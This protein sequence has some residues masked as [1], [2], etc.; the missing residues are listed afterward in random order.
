[1]NIDKSFEVVVEQTFDIDIWRNKIQELRD[2]FVTIYQELDL[3]CKTPLKIKG[4]YV[5]SIS[6]TCDITDFY[7]ILD[8]L[9]QRYLAGDTIEVN[10]SVG[11]LVD[12]IE[13]CEDDEE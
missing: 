11:E 12:L 7:E 3:D 10:Q 9:K 13:D 8:F 4:K 1:M 6:I 5:Y 2:C